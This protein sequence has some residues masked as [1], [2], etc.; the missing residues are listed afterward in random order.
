MRGGGRKDTEG[1][2]HTPLPPLSERRWKEGRG[3]S[4]EGI[5]VRR[6]VEMFSNEQRGHSIKTKNEPS[7]HADYRDTIDIGGAFVGKSM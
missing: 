5:D 1:G 6:T 4:R 2:S 7:C 3:P